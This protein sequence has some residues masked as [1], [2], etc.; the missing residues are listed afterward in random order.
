MKY[1]VIHCSEDGYVSVEALDAQTLEAR[2]AQGYW[3]E[4]ERAPRW[5]SAQLPRNPHE[6]GDRALIV[7]GEA[8]TPRAV[9]VVRKWE[10]P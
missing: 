3:G 7:K 2:L 5:A 4:G 9:D 10:M 1:Y 6:W 8:V